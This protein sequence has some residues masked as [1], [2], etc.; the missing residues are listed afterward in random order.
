[1]PLTGSIGLRVRMASQP[2]MRSVMSSSRPHL[3]RSYHITARPRPTPL[4]QSASLLSRPGTNQPSVNPVQHPSSRASAKRTY[5]ISLDVPGAV[6]A[7]RELWLVFQHT[8]GLPWFLTIP[9][10]ALG[11]NLA[12]RWPI[13]VYTQQMHQRRIELT[14]IIRA[15]NDRNA[16]LIRKR[17][18]DLTPAEKDKA[19]AKLNKK[20]AKRIFKD[21]DVQRWKDYLPFVVF[22]VWLFNMEVLRKL[23]GVG[24]GFLGMVFSKISGNEIAFGSSAADPSL[25]TG[26][27][28]WFPDLTVADPY[29][30]LPGMLSVLLV[31]NILPESREGLRALIGMG[32]RASAPPKY[33]TSMK[34]RL[35]VQRTLLILSAC[36]GPLTAS[37][38][39]AIHFYWV[40]SAAVTLV[41]KKLADRW[42]PLP[43]MPKIEVCK[44]RLSFDLMPKREKKPTK[45]TPKTTGQ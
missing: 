2:L 42:W 37:F 15:W 11:L 28:L 4:I 7:T 3:T 13:T 14:N 18:P 32:S 40:T 17:R 1:M 45:T 20:S 16:T 36:A 21:F 27:F 25:V 5:I 33:T 19:V 44:G 26:G 35:A 38:P 30:I 34:G 29:H 43:K 6:E 8:T 31:L 39:A 22:P 24:H 9:L 41:M 12:T 10:I 23:S